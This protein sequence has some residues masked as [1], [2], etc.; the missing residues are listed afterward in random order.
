MTQF[1]SL[2]LLYNQFNNLSD[3]I[4]DMVKNEEYSDLSTKLEDKDKLINKIM[5]ARKTVI[6]ADEDKSKLEAMDKQLM[7]KDRENLVFASQ[8]HKELGD[9]LK[10]AN[11]HVKMNNAYEQLPE[12]TSG[13][14][15]N[16]SE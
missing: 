12:E 3:E 4:K 8:V 5:N 10:N 1:E 14:Y 13:V 2:E 7:E 9:E 16:L 6:I 15:V 11:K